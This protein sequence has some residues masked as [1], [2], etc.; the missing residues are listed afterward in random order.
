MKIIDEY[1][2]SL[3]ANDKSQEVK[4]LKEELKGHLV[5]ST[6]EFIAKGYSKEDAQLEAINQ[7]DDGAEMLK[8]L[9]KA[10]NES[11]KDN[12]KLNKRFINIFRN[13]FILSLI[14]GLSTLVYE[15]RL[16]DKVEYLAY[17]LRGELSKA[18]I[19]KRIN[20]PE[21]YKKQLENILKDKEFKYVRFVKITLPSE[22]KPVYRYS[23]NSNQTK[24]MAMR[25]ANIGIPDKNGRSA[26]LDLG[27]DYRPVLRAGSF[28][29][30][31]FYVGVLSLITYIVLL[32]R[33]KIKFKKTLIYKRA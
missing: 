20:K 28:F 14:V 12:E 18:G 1:L 29:N 24:S 16:V 6:N 22:K 19:E 23:D 11:K 33:Y 4:D 7:F 5:T 15:D 17:A 21:T 8:D 30:G 26:Y 3:Y 31:V 27:I 32:V 13:I 10:L 25:G 2:N 9:H